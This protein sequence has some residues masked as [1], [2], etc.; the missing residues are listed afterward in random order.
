LETFTDFLQRLVSAV[1]KVLSDP[2]VRQVLIETLAFE[3][4][5]AK[6]K[7]A[8]RLLKAH[9]TPMDEWI[10]DM[11]DDASQVHHTNI[12]GQA[13]ARSLR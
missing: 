3:N 10:R 2:D 9:T 8:I 1:N 13:I 6:Y 7:R 12:I 4:V 5:N 11:T